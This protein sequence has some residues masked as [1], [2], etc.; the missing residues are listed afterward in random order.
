M[1]MNQFED[2]LDSEHAVEE[3]LL[4]VGFLL[5]QISSKAL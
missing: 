2:E 5:V 1:K 4:A 3:P